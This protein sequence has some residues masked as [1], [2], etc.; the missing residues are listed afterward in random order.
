MERQLPS[1]EDY[2]PP[3][4]QAAPPAGGACADAVTLPA[5]AAIPSGTGPPPVALPGYH[6]E[7]ELGRGGM[8]VVYKAVQ[9]SLNRPVALKMLLHGSWA[10][11][12]DVERFRLEA[13]AVAQLDHPN[14]IPVYEVG[15]RDGLHYFT[16]KLVEGSASLAQH[17]TRLAGDP[18]AAVRLLATVARAV[19][20]AHQR[21]IIHRDL[22][23]ANVLLGPD[24]NPYVTD[25]G[26][27]K[28]TEGGSDL[29]QTG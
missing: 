26:L 9:V 19:H 20:H 3:T 22:K 12:A 7:A 11:P 8:G 27:A 21:G 14:I 28:R 23:P 24:Q 1:T 5:A 6:L 17:M 29:T 10:S 13:D 18:R 4:G 15:V 2:L 16:M 25:F